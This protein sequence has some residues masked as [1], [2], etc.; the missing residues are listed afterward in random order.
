MSGTPCFSTSQDGPVVTS[1]LTS[2]TMTGSTLTSTASSTLH[3]GGAPSQPTTFP[4]WDWGDPYHM[5]TARI[6]PTFVRLVAQ[7][8]G[9][10]AAPYVAS[11]APKYRCT[12]PLELAPIH[13]A[14]LWGR[15][16]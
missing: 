15:R 8:H 16:S 12:A 1:T 6:R 2:T 5:T 10:A 14:I 7:Q 3:G 4:A 11:R 13:P 9:G